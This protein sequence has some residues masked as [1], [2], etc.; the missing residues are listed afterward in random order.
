[1]SDLVRTL[2]AIHER[3]FSLLSSEAGSL[4]RLIVEA[5]GLGPAIETVAAAIGWAAF[6]RRR[7]LLT[8]V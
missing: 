7:H 8:Y 1:M 2:A 6:T 3:A 4:H 5:Q